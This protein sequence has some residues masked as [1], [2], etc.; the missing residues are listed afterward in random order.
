MT[1]PPKLRSRVVFVALIVACGV[2]LLSSCAGGPLPPAP[3]FPLFFLAGVIAVGG[4]L[5]ACSRSLT[6]PTDAATGGTGWVDAFVEPPRDAVFDPPPDVADRPPTPACLLDDQFDLS[7]PYMPDAGTGWQRCCLRG[8]TR[9]CPSSTMVACNYGMGTIFNAD[10]TCAWGFDGGVVDVAPDAMPDA[11]ADMRSMDQMCASQCF[12]AP[13]CLDETMPNQSGQ[14]AQAGW[15]SCC[16][17][18]QHR[19]C[20]SAG[21][22]L[23]GCNFSWAAW[24]GDGTCVPGIG[25]SCAPADASDANATAP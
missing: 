6:T 24:C 14:P 19:L 3:L 9:L 13:T 4:W 25:A 22:P 15:V 2:A 5:S 7:L 8:Q 12:T 10:G 1:R 21:L 16:L 18:G 11:T 17:A 23:G 20:P